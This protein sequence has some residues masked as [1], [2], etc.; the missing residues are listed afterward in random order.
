MQGRDHLFLF[1]AGNFNFAHI[2]CTMNAIITVKNH[3]HS[4][5]P[6]A[7]AQE[8]VLIGLGKKLGSQ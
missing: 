6:V 4:L 5:E 7:I 1:S 3:T 2:Y 8:R